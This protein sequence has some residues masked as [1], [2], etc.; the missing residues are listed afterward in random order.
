MTKKLNLPTILTISRMILVVPF[1]VLTLMG[2][3]LELCFA[4][5]VFAAAAVTDKIDGDLA[6]KNHQVTE[7]GKFLDPLADK[8]LVNVAF[9]CLTV[10]EVVPVWI[11][12]LILCRDFAVDGLR[13]SLARK[14]ETVAASI[15][16]KLKTTVQM[17]ALVVLI[18][19][20]IIGGEF[21][22][23]AGNVLLYVALGL[24]LYSGADYIIKGWSKA[25]K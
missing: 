6:R 15:W 2:G 14:G 3:K 25:I 11:F 18:A 4:L 10:A 17:L 12:A 19:E 24:T 9:L 5:V 16:G 20:M 21:L 8:M 13:M 23:I 22:M 7:L 1:M